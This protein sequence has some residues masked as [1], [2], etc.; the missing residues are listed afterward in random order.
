M[1]SLGE[2]PLTLTGRK[3][4]QRGPCQ[5]RPA[6]ARKACNC[7]LCSRWT[8][9][10]LACS[11]ILLHRRVFKG[12][13]SRPTSTTHPTRSKTVQNSSEFFFMPLLVTFDHF[14]SLLTTFGYFWPLL[15]TSGHFWP[16]FFGVSMFR[17]DII[18]AVRKRLI[19]CRNKTGA[20][21]KSCHSIN[22]SI[23]QSKV[24]IV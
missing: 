15:V 13:F 6:A 14:W 16:I 17:E 21:E 5:W 24:V 11:Y 22:Q 8:V 9:A 2:L 23:N 12:R 20:A 7:G 3:D 1:F 10:F 4:T 18:K 19:F